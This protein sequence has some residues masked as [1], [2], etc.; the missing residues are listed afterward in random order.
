MLCLD[1]SCRQTTNFVIRLPGTAFTFLGRSEGTWLESSARR[2]VSQILKAL[3]VIDKNG[4][5][6]AD[7]VVRKVVLLNY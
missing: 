4:L 2:L 6:H 3:E 5:V 1:S 7:V